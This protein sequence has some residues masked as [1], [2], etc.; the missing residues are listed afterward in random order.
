M[1]KEREVREQ[2][3]DAFGAFMKLVHER[4]SEEDYY[5]EAIGEVD[6]NLDRTDRAKGPTEIVHAALLILMQVE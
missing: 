3:A 2:G 4:D 5:L 1:D 6:R